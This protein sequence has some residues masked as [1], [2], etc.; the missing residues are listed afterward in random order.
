MQVII[1]GKSELNKHGIRRLRTVLKV[2]DYRVY[3]EIPQIDRIFCQEE[4]DFI[5][6]A[7]CN[8]KQSNNGRCF[9]CDKWQSRRF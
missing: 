6:V 1:E 9:W 3:H 8:I 5:D 2:D 4:R 7:A